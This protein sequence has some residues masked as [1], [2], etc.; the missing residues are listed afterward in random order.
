[1]ISPLAVDEVSVSSIILT[2]VA[3]Y[4]KYIDFP[5]SV[6]GKWAYQKLKIYKAESKYRK[7]TGQAHIKEVITPTNMNDTN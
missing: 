2:V 7:A 6:V 4:S 3:L 5:T 1:G